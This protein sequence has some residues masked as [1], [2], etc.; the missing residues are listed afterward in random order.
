MS[1]ESFSRS[2]IEDDQAGPLLEPPGEAADI[3]KGQERRPQAV[4]IE[5]IYQTVQLW[6][7]KKWHNAPSAKLVYILYGL[8]VIATLFALLLLNSSGIGPRR[9]AWKH[10]GAALWSK[11]EGFKIIGLVFFGRRT[12]VEIL[13]CYLKKNLVSN[14]GYLDEVHFVAF[15]S[16]E[17][18]DAWLRNLVLSAE[19]YQMVTMKGN[20]YEEVWNRTVERNH[21]YIKIDDDLVSRM[22]S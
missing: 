13:D 18:D 8:I 11:P 15:K 4:S 10:S 21:M 6:A 12:T 19:E 9:N 20:N 2:S 17:A 14:G 16:T 22:S 5:S 7:K 1:F 3:E